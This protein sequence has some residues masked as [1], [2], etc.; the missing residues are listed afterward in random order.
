MSVPVHCMHRGFLTLRRV[1]QASV[2]LPCASALGE[3]DMS[4]ALHCRAALVG[5]AHQRGRAG[6]FER[7][8]GS[9][10]V[11]RLKMTDIR[12]KFQR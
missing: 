1:Q 11:S 5:R 10:A 4:C 8:C 2:T 9:Y 6:C 12:T 7:R 3:L